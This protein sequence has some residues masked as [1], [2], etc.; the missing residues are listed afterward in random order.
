MAD[1]NLDLDNAL[2]WAE[3]AT[4]KAESDSDDMEIDEL[5]QGDLLNMVQ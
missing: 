3:K 4:D 2:E 1:G 5:D